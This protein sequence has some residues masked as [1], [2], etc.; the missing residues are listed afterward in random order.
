M[1]MYP[2]LRG[3]GGAPAD[4][5]DITWSRTLVDSWD[6]TDSLASSENN[7]AFTIDS[8]ATRSS[9]GLLIEANNARVHADLAALNIDWTPADIEL[10]ME[11]PTFN[12][13]DTNKLFFAFN[14]DRFDNYSAGAIWQGTNGLHLFYPTDT[15][16]GRGTT[17]ISLFRTFLTKLKTQGVSFYVM[18]YFL[19]DCSGDLGANINS[20]MLNNKS[21]M[22][23]GSGYDTW[24]PVGINYKA[25]R[26]YERT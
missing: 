23:L 1:A 4:P 11:F 5:R 14:N 7:I 18:G 22:Y 25:L 12:M 13:N 16:P 8:G 26:I 15:A 19:T 10:D 17:Q 20:Q 3:G 9:S 24:S 6:F 21:L 2:C